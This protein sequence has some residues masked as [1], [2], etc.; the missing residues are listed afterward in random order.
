MGSRP[1]GSIASEEDYPRQVYG[2]PFFVLW[3]KISR[4]KVEHRRRP[5]RYSRTLDPG[6]K[7]LSLFV[8]KTFRRVL[9]IA[10][11]NLFGECF[12]WYLIL[13]IQLLRKSKTFGTMLAILG[14]IPTV[15]AEPF[16][17]EKVLGVRDNRFHLRFFEK[18]AVEEGIHCVSWSGH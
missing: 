12:H 6:V 8:S 4:F 17:Q 2:N 11:S 10:N 5:I 7:L 18:A 3:L 1:D 14:L 9:T 16:L 15:K 13:L